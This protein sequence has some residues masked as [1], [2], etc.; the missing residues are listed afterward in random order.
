MKK[1][2]F[3]LVTFMFLIGCQNQTTQD[4]IQDESLFYL[5][6][7]YYHHHSFVLIDGEEL[8]YLE[9]NNNNFIVFVFMPM[10]QAS[11]LFY[12]VVAEFM[13]IHE[14]S[15]YRIPFSDI[16]GTRMADAITYFPTAVI[17]REGLVR[18]YL[19]PDRD[20]HIPYYQSAIGFESW[21]IQYIYLTNE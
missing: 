1:V 5:N 18:T 4:E 20:E 2:L 12:E 3:L 6:E 19:Q 10:C 16:E 13:S 9:N 17:Y 7:A 8:K 11:A 21:L 14:L 15:M